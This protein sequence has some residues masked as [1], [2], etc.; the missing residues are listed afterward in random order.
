M[1]VC[2][3]V[4]V[5]VCVLF[6]YVCVYLVAA[7]LYHIQLYLI[8]H[9]GQQVFEHPKDK[10]LSCRLC[11]RNFLTYFLGIKTIEKEQTYVY[12]ISL[13]TILTKL[14]TTR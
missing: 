9:K 1:C 6:T 3:C 11:C 4:Y 10:W 13:I 7:I 5:C 2:V 8:N 14:R 12:C